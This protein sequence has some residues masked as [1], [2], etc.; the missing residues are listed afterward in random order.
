M[1]SRSYT[2]TVY[3]F[4]TTTPVLKAHVLVCAFYEM[5]IKS[6]SEISEQH[7]QTGQDIVQD[8][9]KVIDLLNIVLATH[10]LLSRDITL[11]FN[12]EQSHSIW[13]NY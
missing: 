7:L 12:L 10:C 3:S 5:T 1:T 9:S 13:E 4:T 6:D 8:M 2:E 11:F